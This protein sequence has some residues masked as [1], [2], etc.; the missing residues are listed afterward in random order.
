LGVL[1]LDISLFVCLYKVVCS[2]DDK[3]R[4]S[5][6]CFFLKVVSNQIFVYDEKHMIINCCQSYL[7][8]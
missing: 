2:I 1:E 3:P 8:I 7:A 5:Y 4:I 6:Y